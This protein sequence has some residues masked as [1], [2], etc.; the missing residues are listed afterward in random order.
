MSMWKDFNNAPQQASYDLI[1]KGTIV[2]VRMMLKPG[3]YNDESQGWT[4]GYA[5]QNA[6][7]GS[8]Y[9]AA[10]FVILEGEFARRKV[11]ANIGLK[12]PKGPT[13]GE[14]GRGFLRAA[15]NS[16]RNIEPR[17]TSARAVAARCVNGLHD[18]DGLEFIARID[19]EKDA[20]G[21]LRNTIKIA[22]EPGHSEYCPVP[23]T[24][25]L[26]HYGP[27]SSTGVA[28]PAQA[29]VAGTTVIAGKPA[30]AQ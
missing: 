1:P 22:I 2:P 14:I 27:L 10:E 23:S 19:H 9:L 24:A 25:T 29:K 3:G 15:L 28:H 11:W 30:W 12:S 5:T 4:G 18:L 8:I 6:A 21:E 20:N 17:D 16:A 13:W 7:T 26:P